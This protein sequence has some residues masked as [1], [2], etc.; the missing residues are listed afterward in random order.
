M[1]WASTPP[2]SQPYHH[3]NTHHRECAT[4]NWF[5]ITTSPPICSS[6]SP[7]SQKKHIWSASC[8]PFTVFERPQPIFPAVNIGQR[9]EARKA[10]KEKSQTDQLKKK[11]LIC[12]IKKENSFAE[13]FFLHFSFPHYMR[14]LIASL[15]HMDVNVLRRAYAHTH[16]E[17]AHLVHTRGAC[18]RAPTAL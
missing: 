5:A 11:D 16:A 3:T 18:I 14:P 8:S 12:Q 2:T 6:P 7:K 1:A 10:R 4:M 13:S 17:Y 9:S 15:A